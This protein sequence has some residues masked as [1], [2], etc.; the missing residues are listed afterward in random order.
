[1]DQAYVLDSLGD[2]FPHAL[3]NAISGARADLEEFRRAFPH[4]FPPMT[5][6]GLANIIWERVWARLCDELSDHPDASIVQHGAT[7]EIYIGLEWVLRVKRHTV[8]NAIST[9]ATQTA[10]EF[11]EQTPALDGMQMTSLAAGYQWDADLNSIGAPVVSYRDGKDNP[12]WMVRLD[13]PSDGSSA[14]KWTNIDPQL[15]DITLLTDSDD[16]DKAA[17]SE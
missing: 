6:R 12:I 11:Y 9:Y 13:E 1:M 7:N 16:E 10:I 8:D 4:W 14:F 5:K 17:D 2:K 15:P 3:S